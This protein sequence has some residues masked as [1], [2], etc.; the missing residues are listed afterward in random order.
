MCAHTHARMHTHIYVYVY[1]PYIFITYSL[2]FSF[3]NFLG[4]WVYVFM[5]DYIMGK[6]FVHAGTYV[7][8]CL[9][10][11]D[12]LV[13]RPSGAVYFCFSCLALLGLSQGL[14]LT[15]NSPSNWPGWLARRSRH[16]SLPAVSRLRKCTPPCPAF[17]NVGSGNGTQI[18]VS[19]GKHFYWVTSPSPPH[20]PLIS[21]SRWASLQ[22]L[23]SSSLYTVEFSKIT[24]WKPLFS[25]HCKLNPV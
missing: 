3:Y 18:L 17:F 23:Y 11:K 14:P 20:T 8:T 16:L 10:T 13:C 4:G 22:L 12:S 19:Q 7:Y 24:T 9:P 15:W 2:F 5:Y 21:L 25:E 1:I 6:A